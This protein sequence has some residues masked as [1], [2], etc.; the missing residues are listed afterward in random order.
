MNEIKV[1]GEKKVQYGT[2][3]VGFDR[4]LHPKSPTFANKEAYL[5]NVGL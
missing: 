3:T 1:G 2:I 4:I 5:Q